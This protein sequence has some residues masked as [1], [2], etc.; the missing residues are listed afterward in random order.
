MDAL[1]SVAVEICRVRQGSAEADHALSF[2]AWLT[3]EHLLLL[4]MAA[5]AGDEAIVLVRFFDEVVA[6]MS[7]F[8]EQI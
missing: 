4:S 8:H 7:K 6:D 1:I 5:D 2:L 3:D